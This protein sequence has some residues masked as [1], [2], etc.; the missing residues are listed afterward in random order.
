MSK[1]ST[2]QRWV[3]WLERFKKVVPPVLQ[4]VSIVVNVIRIVRDL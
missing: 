2:E 1:G 3:K 4:A